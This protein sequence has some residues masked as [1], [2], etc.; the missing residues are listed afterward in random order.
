MIDKVR[1]ENTKS[2]TSAEDTKKE[3]VILSKFWLGLVLV[4]ASSS[5]DKG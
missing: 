2:C 5:T 4:V 3:T 1:V